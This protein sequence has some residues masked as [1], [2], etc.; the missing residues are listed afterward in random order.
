MIQLV[1]FLLV[2]ASAIIVLI[3]CN[4]IHT[5]IIDVYYHIKC[6]TALVYSE[7]ANNHEQLNTYQGPRK[8]INNGI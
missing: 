7:F 4:I 3:N 1:I 6:Y 8:H 2:I 5:S